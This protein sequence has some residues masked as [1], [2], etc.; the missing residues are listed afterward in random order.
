MSA[1][2]MAGLPAILEIIREFAATARADAWTLFAP[3]H[4]VGRRKK[5]L[6]K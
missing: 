3:L 4:K 6:E 5:M 1:D 2:P